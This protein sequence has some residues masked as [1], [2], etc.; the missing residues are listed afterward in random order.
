MALELTDPACSH[1][2]SCKAVSTVTRMERAGLRGDVGTYGALVDGYAWV[3]DI[4]AGCALYE[5]LKSGQTAVTQDTQEFA[6]GRRWRG[7][8]AVNGGSSDEDGSGRARATMAE[9][10]DE[11]EGMSKVEQRKAAA[12]QRRREESDAAESDK[13]QEQEREREWEVA[14]PTPVGLGVGAGVA[15]DARMRAALVAACG[16]AGSSFMAEAIISDVNVFVASG[17][18]EVADLRATLQRE[19]ERLTGAVTTGHG[20]TLVHIRVQLEQIQDTPMS[21]VGL[22]DGQKCSS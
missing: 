14:G 20:L 8:D 9:S 10:A 15:P 17:A 1:R 16:R 22:H 3:G 2:P 7:G 18:A 5:N 6:R 19:R 11:W 4:D 21:Q 12:K 13:E